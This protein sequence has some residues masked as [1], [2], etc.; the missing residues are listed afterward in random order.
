LLPRRSSA[1]SRTT[2]RQSIPEL[3]ASIARIGLLQNLIVFLAPMASNTKSSQRPP[4]DRLEAAAKKS[5]SPPTTKCR[6]C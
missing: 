4:P 6:A 3:A 5:A 2:P 1:T